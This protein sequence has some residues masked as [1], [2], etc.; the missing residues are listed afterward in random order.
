MITTSGSDARA[1]ASAACPS[2]TEFDD[3]AG[4][5]KEVRLELA[6]V[7]IALD[8]QHAHGASFARGASVAR[9][10]SHQRCRLWTLGRL[11]RVIERPA[12]VIRE[13]DKAKNKRFET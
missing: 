6:H 3:V 7:L 8:D 13:R 10:G 1:S 5:A 2:S 12:S 4:R 9:G 11:G